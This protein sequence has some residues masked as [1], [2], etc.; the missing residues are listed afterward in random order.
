[1]NEVY[2][3]L[4]WFHLATKANG[5]VRMCVSAAQGPTKGLLKNDRGS[6][7]NLNKNG[8]MDSR[9]AHL[10][11]EVRSSILS[12][13]KHP[14]CSRCWEEESHG[15]KSKRLQTLE[16]FDRY[17]EAVDITESDGSI[18]KDYPYYD[19]DLRFGNLC[20]LKCRMCGPADSSMWYE[21]FFKVYGE[22]FKDEGYRWYEKARVWEE[23]DSQI[24]YAEN[25]Y[26]I[27]GEPTLIQKHFEFL[28]RCIE[29]GHAE[30]INLEYASNITNIHQKYLD[31]WSHFKRVHVGCSIDG[32]A[33]VNEYIRFPSR[34]K[35][36]EKNLEKLSS[37][38]A[39]MHVVI[40]H[41]VNAYNVYYLDDIYRWNVQN[42]N[43]II[44][45][46]PLYNPREL[47]VKIFPHE[48]K[49]TIAEKL[50]TFYPWLEQNNP[51]TN[52]DR[53][54]EKIVKDIEGYIDFMMSED[55]SEKLP[56]FWD[57]TNKLD[58]IRK[59]NISDSLPEL[60]D[61]IKDTEFQRFY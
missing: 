21:D 59:Q 32:V 46:H 28:E 26:I 16:Y 30:H 8:I 7:Y 31:I 33:A 17:G 11:R 10:V 34:W 44:S 54:T 27:G 36:I 47:S 56:K 24:P 4:P 25:M 1:M 5:D 55:L 52:Y 19:Y 53:S 14:E 58:G 40:A 12:G 57:Q 50:R 13:T 51:K 45:P 23:L 2:C 48:V 61:L 18:P 29:R 60:Y 38:A 35:S 39:N 49:L 22:E 15:I 43:F 20:N 41:T 3:P 37:C 42:F 9:N 6:T